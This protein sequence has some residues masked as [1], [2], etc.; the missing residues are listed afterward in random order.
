MFQIW[1]ILFTQILN[2]PTELTEKVLAT[3]EETSVLL[4]LNGITVVTLWLSVEEL[5]LT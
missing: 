4:G 1:L 3:D 2:C 5:H